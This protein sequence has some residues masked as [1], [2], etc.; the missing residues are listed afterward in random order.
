MIFFIDE[1]M[2]HRTSKLLPQRPV[3]GL[4]FPFGSGRSH[5]LIELLLLK[6]SEVDVP[7]DMAGRFLVV[8]HALRDLIEDRMYLD[9]PLLS[10]I[11]IILNGNVT[12]FLMANTR[13]P[14]R[15]PRFRV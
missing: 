12:G 1:C 8:L 4:L 10:P 13:K 6:P 5:G 7:R 3:A 14:G 15:R 2:Y 9:S 11:V